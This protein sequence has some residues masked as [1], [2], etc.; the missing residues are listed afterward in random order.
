MRFLFNKRE[1]LAL[2]NI[3]LLGFFLRVLFLDK[4]PVGFHSQEA[5]IGYRAFSL[6]NTARDELGRLLPILFTSFKDYQ[7]PLPTYLTIPSIKIFGLNEWATRLPFAILGTLAIPA[8]YGISRIIFPEK[9]SIALWTAFFLAINPW[10]VFLSRTTSEIALAFHLLII[11][12]W[13]LLYSK[14]RLFFFIPSIVFIISSLYSSKVAWFFIPVFLLAFLLTPITKGILEFKIKTKIIFLT[15]VFLFWLPILFF[16]F[17]APLAKESL[18]SNDLSFFKDV[19]TLNYINEMRGESISGGASFLSQLFFNKSFYLLRLLENFFMHFNPHFLFAA[20]SGQSLIGLTNFGPVLVIFLPVTIFGLFLLLKNSHKN[21]FLLLIWAF[22]AILPSTLSYPTLN[23]ER[24][25]FLL[26]PIAVVAAYGI[27]FIK[28]R[29]LYFIFVF[30]L[31]F[32]LSFVSFDT[33]AKEPKRMQKSWLYGYKHLSV[34]FSSQLPNY[35]KIYLT[36]KYAEDPIP[37]ILFY[38][39]YLPQ[40][41]WSLY[42]P[43]QKFGY[44]NWIGQI[45]NIQVGKIPTSYSKT[46]EKNLFAASQDELEKIP[47]GKIVETIYDLNGN[48]ILQI[49]NFIKL[50]NNDNPSKK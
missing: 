36:D 34:Y 50:D 23:Q 43:E 13:F 35:D 31:I 26:P 45:D 42:P 10:S 28:S 11:G 30:G 29:L 9:K 22:L 12:F 6:L 8:I 47:T 21:N 24:L 48:P 33:V 44:K 4:F 37:L 16:Y 3:V 40:K 15:T 14:E 17:S 38:L 27:S 19:S 32:N 46:D 41:S 20:G 2:L 49:G 5:I 1:N 25:I 18:V 7:L 39:K